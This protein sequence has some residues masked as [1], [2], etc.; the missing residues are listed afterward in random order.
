MVRRSRVA[1]VASGGSAPSRGRKRPRAEASQD[2]LLEDGSETPPW[3]RVEG[4]LMSAA[5]SVRRAYD[6]A[7]AEIGIN[8]SEASILAHLANSGAITQVELA[9]R[10]GA[11][12]ARIGVHVDTLEAKQAVASR[13]GPA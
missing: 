7:F 3:S 5:R 4:T 8:L 10:I 1:P 6:A 12:R 11:S 2:V 13:S 9:R